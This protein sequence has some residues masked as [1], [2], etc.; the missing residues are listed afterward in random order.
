[1]NENIFWVVTAKVKEGE[2]G[3]LKA[4]ISEMTE[5]TKANEPGAINYEWFISSDEKFCH[6]YERYTNSETTVSHLKN[7]NKNYAKRFI[8]CLDVKSYTVYGKPSEEV[9]NMLSPLGVVF[10]EPAGGFI[11]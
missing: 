10:M 7:F 1:M 4:L 6:V 11:R 2:I 8:G 5:S 3:N 9:V